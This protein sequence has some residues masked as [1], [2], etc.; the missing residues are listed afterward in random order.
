MLTS[1]S[2]SPRDTDSGHTLSVGRGQPV[3]AAAAAA[4]SDGMVLPT[5]FEQ[6][7]AGVGV[8][9][10]G[11]IDHAAQACIIRDG[12]A[13]R[14]GGCEEQTRLI[15]QVRKAEQARHSRDETHRDVVA[16]ASWFNYC[17]S[18][19]VRAHLGAAV[20]PTRFQFASENDMAAMAAPGVRLI[21]AA[22]DG[23]K[24]GVK[25]WLDQG[26]DVDSR[27]WDNLTPLI[28]ASSQGHLVSFVFQLYGCVLWVCVLWVGPANIMQAYVVTAF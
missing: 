16:N 22:S 6:A 2:P 23:D 24:K 9:G 26:V 14:M 1:I 4:A 25:K 17:L 10:V 13:A 27:D 18:D 20:C 3:A 15:L 19:Y 5:V 21:T 28:A 12:E 8:G 7:A 11:A